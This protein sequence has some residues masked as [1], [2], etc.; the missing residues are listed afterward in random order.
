MLMEVRDFDEL[1][2]DSSYE[3][4]VKSGLWGDEIEKVY[5]NPD[6]Y[7]L[8]KT[9]GLFDNLPLFIQKYYNIY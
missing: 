8:T 7:K 6:K 5:Y 3:V 1:E 9:R 4:V 2:L